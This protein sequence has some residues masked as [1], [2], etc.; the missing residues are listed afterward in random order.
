MHSDGGNTLLDFQK[1]DSLLEEMAHRSVPAASEE[2]DGLIVPGPAQ[3]SPGAKLTHYAQPTDTHRPVRMGDGLE[4]PPTRLQPVAAEASDPGHPPRLTNQLQYLLKVVLKTLWKHHFAWPFHAPVDVVKLNLPDY[5][6]IIK[7]PMDMGTIKKRLENNYYRNA[8]ECIQ[9]F[10][11]MF[12]NCYMY[13]KRGEDIVLMAETLEKLFLQKISEMPQEEIEMPVTS[14]GRGRR[15][16]AVAEDQEVAQGLAVTQAP[17]MH[18]GPSPLPLGPPLDSS[19]Q[20]GVLDALAQGMTSVP[21]PVPK[22]RKSQKRKADTT[23]GESSPAETEPRPRRVSNRPKQPRRDLPD[24][25]H[26]FGPGGAALSPRTS[27]QLRYCGGVLGDMLS[28]KHYAYAWPF[29]RPVD[30]PALGLHDY[31]DI[32]KHPMDLGTVKAKLESGQYGGAQEFADDIRLMFSNCYKYNPPDHDVVAMGR[33]LQDVFEMRFAKMP[34]DPQTTP[35]PSLSPAPVKQQTAPAPP[36]SSESSEESESSDSD[37]E[38]TQ[39]LAEL[40]EQL[41][42][43]H[44]QL[45]ALSQAQP[46]KPKKKEKEKKKDKHRKKMSAPPLLSDVF[47]PEAT[48]TPPAHQP[49]KKSKSTKESSTPPKTKKPGKKELQKPSRSIT[50]PSLLPSAALESDEEGGG[51]TGAADRCKP[52]TLEEK[53][54]LS[55]DINRLP[56]DKLGRVVHIIQ[57]REPALKS[58]NPDEIEIDFETLKPST[59]RELERYVSSSLRKKK[60]TADK[61]RLKTGSSSGSSSESSDSS[62]SDDSDTGLVPKQRKKSQLGG[63][64]KRPHHQPP[65]PV[66]PPAPPATPAPALQSYPPPAGAPLEPSHLLGNGYNPLAHFGVPYLPQCPAA[67]PPHNNTTHADT[68]G[69]LPGNTHTHPPPD[70][71]AFLNQHPP[72]AASPALHPALPQQPSRPSHRAAPLPPKA[73]LPPPP[74]PPPPATALPA[75][76]STQA[77]PIPDQPLSTCAPVE[78]SLAT[79]SSAHGLRPLAPLAPLVPAPARP[80]APLSHQGTSLLG[81]VSAQPPQALLE[82]EEDEESGSPTLPIGHDFLMQPL[83]F[84]PASQTNGAPSD[85]HTISHTQLLRKS[86]DRQASALHTSGPLTDS[87]SHLMSQFHSMVH[88]SPT[89]IPKPALVKE[90]FPP[91]PV[92]SLSPLHPEGL[93]NNLHRTD[94]KQEETPQPGPSG[95]PVLQD[96]MKQEKMPNPS[97]KVQDVKLKNMGSWA[98]LAHRSSSSSSSSSSLR[99]SSDSFEQFRRAA[100]EKEEREKALRAEQA[101]KERARRELEKRGGEEPAEPQRQ[102]AEET[103]RRREQAPPPPRTPTPPGAPPQPTPEQQRE[104]ARRREQERRRREAMTGIDMNFQSDLMAI[105]EENL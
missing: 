100:R 36:S 40:Q 99:S 53:R 19:Y 45:A 21:P 77:L 95:S 94:I 90:K 78:A 20:L 31:H 55:L 47:Y 6:K 81:Q 25:Q 18:V 103:R 15:R 30:A 43:V 79:P 33:K 10:T 46:S 8:Q 54:Q 17:P 12:T 71:H 89:D 9:D 61:S 72:V 59:L 50:P 29:H 88:A 97:A 56:G 96:K 28:K 93:E 44:E 73:H 67:H 39:R 34:D 68:H 52:M 48:P 105:F 11:L 3:P 35:I 101:E 64:G 2:C 82:D 37:Q 84:C 14:K 76:S 63:E 58:S 38:R 102:P 87:P 1:L 13:N 104:L 92:L 91:S 51:A 22:Q 16:D 83:V 75:L 65:P 57:S 60:P 42:A 5:Y 86:P 26:A 27:E 23:T 32:I 62:D 4:A 98:S 7:N 66:A 69:Q 70:T 74:P 41:K 24:S 80:L 49:I 85:S